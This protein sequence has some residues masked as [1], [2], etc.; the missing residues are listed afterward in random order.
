MSAFQASFPAA[1][2]M[3]AFRK[4][5]KT[6]PFPTKKNSFILSLNFEKILLSSYIEYNQ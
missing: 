1:P 3:P 5:S 4:D 6:A 2:R